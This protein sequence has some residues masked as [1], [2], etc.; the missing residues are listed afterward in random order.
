MS[1]KKVESLTRVVETAAQLFSQR[2]FDQVQISEIAARARCSSATIYEAFETKKGLFRAALLHHSKRSWP[3]IAHGDG[4]AGLS[5]LIEFLAD[6]IVGLSTP[7]MKN[8][9][10]HLSTD[11]A[12]SRAVMQKS[13]GDTP[14]L[15][16]IVDEVQRCMDADLL[17]AGDPYAVSYLL[18]AGTGYE[19]VVYGL[20]F[21]IEVACGAPVIIEMVLTP[22]VTERGANELAAY[23]ASSKTNGAPDEADRPSLLNYMRASPRAPAARSKRRRN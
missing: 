6:R 19:P 2:P 14:H 11:R 17:R 4:L 7:S 1:N 23:V 13:I 9:L 5:R 8:F 3:D 12:H 20:L 22:L 18:M 10:R 15:G 16:E 21:D